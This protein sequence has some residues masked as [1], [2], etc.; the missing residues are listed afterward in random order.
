MAFWQTFKARRKKDAVRMEKA[1]PLT[2]NTAVFTAWN[3][4]AY[5]N[6]IYRG[7]VDAIARNIAKLKGA[8]VVYTSGTAKKTE[9]DNVLNR[10]LQI[11]PNPY[12]T[13]YDFLYKMATHY[14]L[15]NNSF[16]FLDKDERGNVR[17]VYPIT[18]T[19]AD[20]LTD[21]TGAL[22]VQ[23]RFRSGHEVRQPSESRNKI[24]RD[25]F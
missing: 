8:H 7:A 5:S 25:A 21:N 19:Q 1:E 12:I 23:F 2:G 16:A 20:F 13:A 17:A 11:A 4:G 15:F 10:L 3:S 18:C 24:F 14:Y 6:D 22:F 9:G